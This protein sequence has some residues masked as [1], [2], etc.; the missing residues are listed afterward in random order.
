M[1]PLSRKTVL[2]YGDQVSGSSIPGFSWL[3]V[4]IVLLSSAIYSSE[5]HCKEESGAELVNFAFA[6]YLG[7]GFYASDSGEVF[8]LKIPLSTPLTS[9][10]EGESGW[11]FNYPVTFGAAKVDEI[12]G[13]DV[14]DLDSVKT[15]SIIPGIE[16]QYSVSPLWQLI[17]FF[18]LGIAR[19]LDSDTNLRV[20]GAGIKSFYTFSLDGNRLLLG[21]RLLYADQENLD[22][23]TNS[24]FAVFETGLD[25]IIPTDATIDGTPVN[26]SFY[27]INYYY[28]DE[29]V[30]VD[31]LDERLSLE[32]KDEVGFTVS[33]PK[34]SW[35][36]DDPRI[37]FGVQITRND[38]L[39]RLFIGAPFF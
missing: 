30:V 18:D 19:D 35:F 20:M 37:G 16:Y 32:N 10:A 21:N 39:Y 34:F 22:E 24:N 6:N 25:Y 3:P 14:P 27:Y 8:V 12:S 11:V 31:V 36:S 28:L 15:F 38:E 13:S 1:L 29:L 5:V 17:P 9:M 7:S 33:M 2:F 26:L 23:H 4:L